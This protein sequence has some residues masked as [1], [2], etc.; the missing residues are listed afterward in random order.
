MQI[1]LK[2]FA[3]LRIFLY[4][5][6]RKM[7]NKRMNIWH[8]SSVRN[9]G[10]LLS[11]NII[12]QAIGILIYPVLTRMYA[13]EDFALLNLFTSIV[14]VIVIL[15]TAEFQY[16]VVLPEDDNK[17][18]S[19]VH[20]CALL[21]TAAVLIT[22]LS[23][24]FAQPIA[25]LFNA[26]ELARYWWLVPF[27]VLGMSA[28]NILNYWYIRHK[29]FTRI[30]GYQITQSIFSASG[31]IGLGTPGFMSG[32]MIVATVIAPLLSLVISIGLAWKKHIRVLFSIDRQ[33]I[34]S[35]MRE[36]ANFPKFNLPRSLVN[37]ISIALPI[38]IMTPRFG[39]E[40]IGQFSLAMMAAVLPFTLFARACNQV[41]YQHLSVCVQQQKSLRPVLQPFIL[42]TGIAIIAGL[43]LVYVFLPQLVSLVF[44]AKWM[45]SA[46]IMR[47]L[48]PYLLLTPVC[49]SICFLSDIFAKQKIA[50]WLETGYTI[51]MAL[52]LVFG[53][54]Y[55]SFF[56]TVSLF[57]WTR[58]A[59][60]AV[61]LIW[62]LALVH[63]YHASLRK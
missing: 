29:A 18:R 53:T 3:Y 8:S 46:D 43:A 35:V 1:N 14:G 25:R 5:C 52:S 47:R 12:A 27:S 50:L 33:Q 22:A 48:F 58:F 20:V 60:L 31:K 44:G 41:L 55:C 24:P 63:Q 9:V 4:L 56:T 15:S 23:I 36:Y 54:W 34:R 38:W 26:P 32:G 2:K 7:R 61:Q 30:S 39:L 21:L 40:E 28:W 16:A 59:F 62:F 19:I 6:S 51:I 42:W 37:T 57:A 17:A 10:K 45:E 13:P 49:G 11:A